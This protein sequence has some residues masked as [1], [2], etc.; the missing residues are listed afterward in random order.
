MQ[1]FLINLLV[2]FLSILFMQFWLNQPLRYN[3]RNE[4]VMFISLGFAILL[5]MLFPFKISAGLIFDLRFISFILACFYAH[6]FTAAVLG[7]LTI[8]IRAIHGGEGMWI[9]IIAIPVLYLVCMWTRPLF[10]RNK[11]RIRLLLT[12]TLVF[13]T[14]SGVLLSIHLLFNDLLTFGFMFSFIITHIL[15]ML[16]TVYLVEYFHTQHLLLTKLIRME[17][18][19][20]VSHLAASIS[21][22]VRNPLTSSRGFVQMVQESADITEKEKQFL[23]VAIQEMD[24]ATDIIHDY[25]TFAKPAPDKVENL[26]AK[27][28]MEKAIHV[29]QPLANLNNVVISSRMSN[30]VVKGNAGLYI[31][32]LVN[33]MKNSIE[34]MPKGGEIHITSEVH[35]QTVRIHIQDEGIG[36]TP[37]QITRLG[38]PYFSTKERKGTGLGMMVVFRVIEAM[39]GEVQ[40]S[41]E[42][43][44]GTKTTILLPT[45]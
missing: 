8:M 35:N 21:H 22:E 36:M 43:G 2:I 39:N 41:S 34:A 30:E 40:I 19:E 28:M 3:R 42:K 32:A 12:S 37:L 31:Q 23:D 15:G 20:V 13:L 9:P 29:M 7:L 11:I 17:K 26:S 10:N 27:N 6:P 16:L 5:C 24:R 4:F 25:L 44:V 38:E 1:H 14:C 45:G 33:I 18:V